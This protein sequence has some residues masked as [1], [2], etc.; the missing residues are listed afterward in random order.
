MIQGNLW[1]KRLLKARCVDATYGLNAQLTAINAACASNPDISKKQVALV[2][3]S[4]YH[5]G[6]FTQ[7]GN[8]PGP[9]IFIMR[10]ETSYEGENVAQGPWGQNADHIL[11]VL[12]CYKDQ[13]AEHVEVG[14]DKYE[15]AFSVMLFD[16]DEQAMGLYPGSG[17]GSSTYPGR[18]VNGAYITRTVAENSEQLDPGVAGAI[19][20]FVKVWL[21]EK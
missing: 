4:A 8:Y 20:I 17:L 13:D 10:A 7:L 18:N 9:D 11:R 3:P 21:T 5:F 15:Q 1:V 6:E 16:P 14:L 19:S 2:N 12:V